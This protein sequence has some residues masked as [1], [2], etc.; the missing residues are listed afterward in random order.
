MAALTLGGILGLGILAAVLMGRRGSSSDD[1]I[2]SK[3]LT[4]YDLAL[5]NEL[6]ARE[7][8]GWVP[9]R[10]TRSIAKEGTTLKILDDSSVLAFG[11]NPDKETYTITLRPLQKNLTALR[12]EMLVHP[13]QDQGSALGRNP[14]GNFVMTAIEVEASSPDSA[15]RGLVKL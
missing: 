9:I 7:P 10:P 14:G 15:S 13:E 6:K 8:S 1:E 12:I 3:T 11:K 5:A 2:T 4:P